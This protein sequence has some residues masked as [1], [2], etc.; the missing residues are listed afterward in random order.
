MP[1]KGD[2]MEN[3]DWIIARSRLVI[4]NTKRQAIN[5]FGILPSRIL[6]S[7]GKLFAI[8]QGSASFEWLFL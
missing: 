1:D 5:F 2:P 8:T 3:Y 6:D 4:R 7:C